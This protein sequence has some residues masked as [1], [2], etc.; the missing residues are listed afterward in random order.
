MDST[1][2]ASSRSEFENDFS[3]FWMKLVNLI[4]IFRVCRSITK[5]ARAYNINVTDVESNSS[6]SRERKLERMCE[7]EMRI[8]YL[9][10]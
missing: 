6:I 3:G 2:F 1:G 4:V 9:K 8:E 10:T 7:S 5:V